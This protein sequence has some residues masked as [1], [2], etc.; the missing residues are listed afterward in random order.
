MNSRDSNRNDEMLKSARLL[1]NHMRAVRQKV[2]G[3]ADTLLVENVAAPNKPEGDHVLIK[4]KS[5]AL[6]RADLL[7]RQGRYP[8]QGGK[9]LDLGLEVSGV[10]MENDTP[11]MALLKGG[12][13]SEYV[14]APRPQV[15]PVPASL[16][17]NQA[18]AI[19]EVWLTGKL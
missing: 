18:A 16:H 3:G 1:K 7:M 9:M 6:N 10:D 12:G 17:V 15:M 4:V 14:Y 13:Y 2:L 19:P 8:N 5:S 11:V